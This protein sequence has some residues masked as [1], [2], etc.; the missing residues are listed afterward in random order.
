[1]LSGASASDA[2]MRSL[3][4]AS[5][6]LGSSA[7]YIWQ[8][9]NVNETVISFGEAAGV[10]GDKHVLTAISGI[11]TGRIA[12]V[13]GVAPPTNLSFSERD[14]GATGVLVAA[15]P[16]T[17]AD[18]VAVEAAAEY[19]SFEPPG[20]AGPVFLKYYASAPVAPRPSDWVMVQ[21]ALQNEFEVT[22]RD[23]YV[24]DA[25]GEFVGVNVRGG[26]GDQCPFGDPTVEGDACVVAVVR[27]YGATPGQVNVTTFDEAGAELR[28]STTNADGVL[29]VRVPCGPPDRQGH[30]AA[31]VF[32]RANYREATTSTEYL[33][34]DHFATTSATVSRAAASSSSPS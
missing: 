27:L 34:V 12:V 18:G 26:P 7:H 17:G 8:T 24:R 20:A 22:L 6:A 31:R 33:Y 19:G 32:A 23:P 13:G 3:L 2:V 10:P 21:D 4:L 29:V 15:L 16:F 25:G 5:L 30:V 9:N 28:T 14:S 1:M 11:T